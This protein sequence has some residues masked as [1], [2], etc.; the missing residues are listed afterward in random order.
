MR[1]HLHLISSIFGF[2]ANQEKYPSSANANTQTHTNTYIH[3]YVYT[4]VSHSYVPHTQNIIVFSWRTIR[5]KKI[6][7]I[8][9]S[10][11]QCFTKH[12]MYSVC[13]PRGLIGFL[14]LFCL[15]SVIISLEKLE[16][17][18]KRYLLDRSISQQCEI[19]AVTKS[20]WS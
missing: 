13:C 11:Y 10:R 3:I 17:W 8:P 2:T 1:H 19:S 15:S 14:L 5:D 16:I 12:L 7:L 9:S 18:L 20:F 6:I 4:Y